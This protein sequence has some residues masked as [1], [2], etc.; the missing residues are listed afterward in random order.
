MTSKLRSQ[1]ELLMRKY[2]DAVRNRDVMIARHRSAVAAQK[3]SKQIAN[4]SGMDHSSEL[5]RMDRRLREEEAKALAMAEL[6]SGG[7]ASI[8]DQFAQLDAGDDMDDELKQLKAKMGM[9]GS[10]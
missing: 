8:E 2:D 7:T 6:N 10:Q 5:S 9:G 3:V 1:L 4:I